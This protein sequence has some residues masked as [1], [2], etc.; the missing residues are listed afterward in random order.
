[1]NPTKVVAAKKK[2]FKAVL[3]STLDMLVSDS[4]YSKVIS[5]P[6]KAHERYQHGNAPLSHRAVERQW[7]YTSAKVKEPC[8]RKKPSAPCLTAYPTIAAWMMSYIT[9]TLSKPLL[10]AGPIQRRAEPRHTQRSPKR[11]AGNGSS[12]QESKLDKTG[13]Q[14]AG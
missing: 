14:H 9:S 7:R 6:E 1:V 4:P 12:T 8:K 2:A 10:K 3:L 13:L 5:P 11:S